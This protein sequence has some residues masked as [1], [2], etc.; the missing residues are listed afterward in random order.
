MIN[1]KNEEH[2]KIFNE[3]LERL[4]KQ[5]QPSLEYRSLLYLLSS[6]ETIVKNVED[7]FDF[8]KLLIFPYS[9]ADN[10]WQTGSS[11]RTTKLAYNLFNNNRLNG[12]EENNPFFDD[13]GETVKNIFEYGNIET[14]INAIKIRF[15]DKK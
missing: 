1:F 12:L 3:F 4:P 13:K 9:F 5:L 15:P 2:K 11:L 7:V 8:E 10:A 6:D 14:Y